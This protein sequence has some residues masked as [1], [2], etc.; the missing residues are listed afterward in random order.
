VDLESI[1]LARVAVDAASDRQASDI[2]LLDLRS[3][4]LLADYFVICSAE[5]E[6]QLR[7]VT[8]AIVESLGQAGLRPLHIEGGTDS[9]W[10]LLDYG[11]VIIH[12]FAPTE[13]EYYRLE[14]LWSKATTV[15]R[16]Q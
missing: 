6:R 8:D 3:V 11:V 10:V 1:D 2:V 15:L 12:V 13:R 4:S 7:A 16:M 5:T 14:K 9:G